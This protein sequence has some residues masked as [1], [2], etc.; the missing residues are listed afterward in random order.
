MEQLDPHW[1]DFREIGI[2]LFF[3]DLPIKFKFP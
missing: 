1:T 2:S 3:E